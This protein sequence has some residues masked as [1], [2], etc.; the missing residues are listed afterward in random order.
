VAI[1]I[2]AATE[3]QLLLDPVFPVSTS[4]TKGRD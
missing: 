2:V 3:H 4:W 1:V